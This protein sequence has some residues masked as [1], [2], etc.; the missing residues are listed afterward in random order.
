MLRIRLKLSEPSI[1]TQRFRSSMENKPN[2]VF[3]HCSASVN[4]A[5]SIGAKD[6]DEWH[7]KRGWGGIGYHYIIRR[8]TGEIEFGCDPKKIGTHTEGFNKNSLAICIIGTDDF[9]PQ[10]F[11]TLGLMYGTIKKLHGIEVERWFCHYQFNTHK[12]CPN[13][14]IAL[15]REFLRKF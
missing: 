2:K 8:D 1:K 14:P 13:I 12:S 6:I 10:Q 15:L 7:K 4:N 5:V 11:H 9:T 3:V